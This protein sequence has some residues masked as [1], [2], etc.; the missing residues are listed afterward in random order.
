MSRRVSIFVLSGML[1]FSCLPVCAAESIFFTPK[2]L[3]A[4]AP[5]SAI[6]ENGVFTLNAISYVGE[7]NWTIWVNEDVLRPGLTHPS[8]EVVRVEPGRIHYKWKGETEY[9]ILEIGQTARKGNDRVDTLM[10]AQ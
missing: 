2:E 7:R 10:S 5:Q 3:S 8:I 4:L 9:L 6:P 1:W